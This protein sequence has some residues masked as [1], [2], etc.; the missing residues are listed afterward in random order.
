LVGRGFSLSSW[1][2][3]AYLPEWVRTRPLGHP[4][5]RGDADLFFRMDPCPPFVSDAGT[6]VPFRLFS[7]LL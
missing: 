7:F 2:F 5:H 1:D 6:V 3:P 4:G